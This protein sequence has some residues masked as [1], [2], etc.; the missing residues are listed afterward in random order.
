VIKYTKFVY[1][2]KVQLQLPQERAPTLPLEE[3]VALARKQQR[4]Q[5]FG[6]RLRSLR[7]A[8]GLTQTE[9]GKLIGASQRVVVYYE[10][11][12]GSPSPELL[13][14]FAKALGVSC[15]ILLGV[16]KPEPAPAE[17]MRLMRRLR[18]VEQLPLQDR[19]TVLK[20]IDALADRAGR[21]KVG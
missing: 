11:E 12:G 14:K 20:M 2:V 13:L 19:Q 18:R 16:R 8:K 5:P 10:R 21:R 7:K 1:T 17:N 3:L 9:L 6:D 4:T 15:E